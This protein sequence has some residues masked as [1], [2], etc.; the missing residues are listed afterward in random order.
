M[1]S[2]FAKWYDIFMSPLEQRKFKRIRSE[3]LKGA[4]GKVLE[5]GSGTGINFPLYDNVDTVI[6]IEPSQP[7]ID[8]SLSKQKSAVVPIEIVN[9]SAENLPFE[10][11]TFDTVVAT[12]VFCTIPN[13]EMAINE[14][15]RVCKPD[16]KILLFE[17]VKMGNATLS[18]MQE[19]L[20]PFWKKVCDGCCLN[21]ETLKAFSNQGLEIERVEHFYKDL[22]VV[23]ALRNRQ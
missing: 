7:M 9:A 11:C 19:S 18:K 5:L 12:L 8:Q 15:K 13:V 10:D 20:T 23:A 17:H 14:V 3:L 21:R 1:S 2:K 6:A 4:S 22:F 16:G